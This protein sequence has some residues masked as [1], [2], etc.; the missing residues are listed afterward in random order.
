MAERGEIVVER[1]EKTRPVFGSRYLVDTSKV[2][3]HNA[4]YVFTPSLRACVC[5]L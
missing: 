5:K 2:L 3:E 1:D 4:W